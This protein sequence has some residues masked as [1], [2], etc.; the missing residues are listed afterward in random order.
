MSYFFACLLYLELVSEKTHTD[1]VS[2]V[3]QVRIHSL[4]ESPWKDDV[5]NPN[6]ACASLSQ[7]VS[8]RET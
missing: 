2:G 6:P 3:F 7:P 5:S 4:E 8:D 1:L